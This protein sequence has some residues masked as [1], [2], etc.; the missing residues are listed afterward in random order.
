M[1]AAAATE[2]KEDHARNTAIIYE[3]MAGFKARWMFSIP[4]I[5]PHQIVTV[6]KEV[7]L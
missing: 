6:L 3:R 5:F 4:W 1:A 7:K 2:Q